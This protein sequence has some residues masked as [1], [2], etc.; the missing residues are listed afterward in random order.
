MIGLTLAS[1]VATTTC[2]RAK[3]LNLS[4]KRRPNVWTMGL[5]TLNHGTTLQLLEF[6]SILGWESY[7]DSS[8]T[9]SYHKLVISL[10]LFGSN[11]NWPQDCVQTNRSTLDWPRL[12]EVLQA[13]TMRQKKIGWLKGN[14]PLEAALNLGVLK[15]FFEFFEVP[16]CGD[17]PN[18]LN[19]RC[20][21]KKKTI[22][23]WQSEKIEIWNSG[24][25]PGSI[26]EEKKLR[27]IDV[28]MPVTEKR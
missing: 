21:K 3:E 16:F 4:K 19:V 8:I 25:H 27:N 13:E 7:K 14:S 17:H 6:S 22:V 26:E 15:V 18:D 23:P 20:M 24:D 2:L 1:L 10:D 9:I 12:L 11:R 28:D 5:L